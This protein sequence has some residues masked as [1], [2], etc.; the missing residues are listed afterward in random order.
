MDVDAAHTS[1][2]G[3]S[4]QRCIGNEMREAITWRN[5]DEHTTGIA[6]DI[7]AREDGVEDER[8]DTEEPEDV[9]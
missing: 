1:P 5:D 8:R 2:G 7:A 3:A 9:E 6:E 4:Q